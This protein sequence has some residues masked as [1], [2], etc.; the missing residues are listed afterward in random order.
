MTKFPGQAETDKNYYNQYTVESVQPTGKET[1]LIRW[2]SNTTL[3]LAF[4]AEYIADWLNQQRL[5]VSSPSSSH[6]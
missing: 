3:H 6:N 2:G 1:C 5:P 4:S